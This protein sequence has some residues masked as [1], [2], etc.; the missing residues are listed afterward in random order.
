MTCVINTYKKCPKCKS[1]DH[2]QVRDYSA[3]W[4]DGEVWCEY[5]NIY[6]REYDAG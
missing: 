6:V 3:M 1:T 4:H 2:L 5:C